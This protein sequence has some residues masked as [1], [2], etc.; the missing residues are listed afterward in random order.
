MRFC[1]RPTA[2]GF[3]ISGMDEAADGPPVIAVWSDYI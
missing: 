1:L 2:T 3:Y